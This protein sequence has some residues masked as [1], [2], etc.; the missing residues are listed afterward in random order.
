MHCSSKVLLHSCR[1]LA[2]H[3]IH[4]WAVNEHNASF[5]PSNNK[6]NVSTPI[7]ILLLIFLAF[8]H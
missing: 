3:N 8:E 4:D 1:V 2:D 5:P 7:Y 6:I